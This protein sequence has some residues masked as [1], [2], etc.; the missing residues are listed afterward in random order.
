M[1]RLQDIMECMSNDIKPP[2]DDIVWLIEQAE[3]VE[4]LHE[5]ILNLKEF[6]SNR[7]DD[8]DFYIKVFQELNSVIKPIAEPD[9][10]DY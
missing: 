7:N 2:W 4:E 6:I 5:T 1:T 8:I 10:Y 3:K 9:G